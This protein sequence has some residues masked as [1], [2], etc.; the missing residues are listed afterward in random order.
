M[1]DIMGRV[2]G[3][4][5]ELHGTIV[6]FGRYHY[7]YESGRQGDAPAAA[8]APRK[9]ATVVYVSDGVAA[10]AEAL[11]RLGPHTSGVGCIYLKDLS[12]NDLSVL[13]AIIAKSF[14]T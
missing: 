2:T 4:E 3:L 8:F 14:A 10:H 5:P 7:R 6:G 12:K 9:T 1:I 11:Q 13:E